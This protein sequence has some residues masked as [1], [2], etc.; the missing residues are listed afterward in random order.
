MTKGRHPRGCRPFLS[1]DPSQP[2]GEIHDRPD[3]RWTAVVDSLADQLDAELLRDARIGRRRRRGAV[4]E[5]LSPDA[6]DV[7]SSGAVRELEAREPDDVVPAVR[8]G[9]ARHV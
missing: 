3:P 6:L 7:L 1:S 2:W 5:G 4:P 9:P 8:A